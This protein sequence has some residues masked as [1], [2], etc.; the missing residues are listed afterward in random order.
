MSTVYD[1]II[2]LNIL[3]WQKNQ[4]RLKEKLNIFWL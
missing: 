2:L 1:K 4:N 3:T